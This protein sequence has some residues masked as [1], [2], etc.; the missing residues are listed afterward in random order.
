MSLQIKPQFLAKDAFYKA[1]PQ[2][3]Y[4]ID[5][6][7]FVVMT[8]DGQVCGL[9]LRSFP[10][11]DSLLRCFKKHKLIEREVRFPE[12]PT[13]LLAGT[14]FQQRVWTA[15]LE[16][17][18]G[19]VLS[20]LELAQRLHMPKAVRAVANAVGAN[21]VSPLIPCHRIVGSGGHMGGY[22]WGLEAKTILLREEGIDLSS[23][24]GLPM[25]ER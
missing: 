4:G 14:P 16:I 2:L 6:K 12:A 3:S 21:P 18:R 8:D 22:H 13:Y 10:H 9:A 11:P 15:L 24:K 17:P 25:G 5:G 23:F 19:V 20:Y 7:W 1:Y